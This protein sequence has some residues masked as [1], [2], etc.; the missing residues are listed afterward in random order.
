MKAKSKT[1]RPAKRKA[2]VAPPPRL[3]TLGENRVIQPY[4]LREVTIIG[5]GMTA[6]SYVQQCALEGDGRVK[7]E[8]EVWLL[9]PLTVI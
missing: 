1:K 5:M 2:T 6:Q 4:P 3:T 7:G 9:M 8:K